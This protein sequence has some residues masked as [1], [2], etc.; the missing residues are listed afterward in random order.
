MVHP[1]KLFTIIFVDD[2]L[3]R[4]LDGGK[5]IEMVNFLNWNFELTYSDV[6][7]YVGLTSIEVK[8]LKLRILDETCYIYISLLNLDWL[9]LHC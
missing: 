2:G 5:L 3:N 7:I 8:S 4:S 1:Q 9:K 6:E